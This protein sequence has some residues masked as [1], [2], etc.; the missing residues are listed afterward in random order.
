MN[1]TNVCQKEEKYLKGANRIKLIFAVVFKLFSLLYKKKKG[2]RC[3][4]EMAEALR[5][6]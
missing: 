5:S 3:C 4:H 1:K 6:D 2:D